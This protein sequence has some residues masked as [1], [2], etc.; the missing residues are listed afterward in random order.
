MTDENLSRPGN[1]FTILCVDDEEN[2]LSS[3]K[4]LFRPLGAAVLTAGS[5]SRAL[6]LMQQHAVHI[7]ISDMRMPEMDGATLLERICQQWPDTV[8]IL[9]TGYADIGATIAAINRGQIYRYLDKP[10]DDQQF[11]FLLQDVFARLR[12]QQDKARLE[13][14]IRQR[15]QELQALNATLEQKVEQRTAELRDA[16]AHIRRNFLTAIKVFTQL[17]ELRASQ[18]AGHSR[19]VAELAKTI[20]RHMGLTAAETQDIMLASLLHDIG[21]IGLPDTLL[22]KPLSHLN[23]QELA[24]YR[25]HA[26]TGQQAM[27]PLDELHTAASLIRHHHE[28]WNGQGY[29][30]KLRGE[31]IPL[32]AR[33]LAV[34]NDF[35]ALQA[36]IL[37]PRSLGREE[38]L[39][40]IVLNAG[41]HYDPA[42]VEALQ[43]LQAQAQDVRPEE[44]LL[45]VTDLRAG[46]VLAR[47]LLSKGGMLLLAAD[48][49]LNE[50][51]ISHLHRY[52]THESDKLAVPIRPPQA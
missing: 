25:E 32:G 26:K 51:L 9:L 21:K 38:A 27:M 1:G 5:G 45:S 43:A 50:K 33:I 29:P 6:E 34:A 11:L 2:I 47:D 46:M 17:T 18:I 19:R 22:Q 7:V 23:A 36:G 41:E 44:N 40:Q 15:N 20:A 31:A 35:D 28:K 49:V 10:W 30:D 39:A 13:E 14:E 42:V 4:R 24:R 12:L 52:Q 48:H 37:V 16:N 3:L 8:R